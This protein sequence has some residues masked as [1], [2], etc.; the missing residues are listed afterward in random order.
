MANIR[1]ISIKAVKQRDLH[2]REIF[3]LAVKK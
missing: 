1:G 2:T 3:I